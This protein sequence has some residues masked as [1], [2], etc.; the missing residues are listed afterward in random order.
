MNRSNKCAATLAAGSIA[1]LAGA[2]SAQCDAAN[3]FVTPPTVLNNG[4]GHGTSTGA[5]FLDVTGNGHLDLL[6]GQG[7]LIFDVAPD[8]AGI[9]VYPGDG[10][11]G[12]GTPFLVGVEGSANPS[13]TRGGPRSIAGGDLTGNG[14]K[15][16]VAGTQGVEFIRNNGDGTFADPVVF[17]DT[18]PGEGINDLDIADVNG[19]GHLDIIATDTGGATV[20]IAYN[21]GMGNFNLGNAEFLFSLRPTAARAGD[22]NNNGRID[23]AIANSQTSP[24]SVTVWFQQ[25][26]GTFVSGGDMPL[27]HGPEDLGVGDF[28]ND[29]NLDV[30]VTGGGG[31]G[32][33]IFY[34][35]GAGG[36]TPAQNVAITGTNFALEL[37]VGDIDGDGVDDIA[38]GTLTTAG[39][40]ALGVLL[41]NGDRTFREGLAISTGLPRKVDLGDLNG[42]GRLEATHAIS[43]FSADNTPVFENGCA[44]ICV[45]D[46]NG[47]GVV[48]A[49]DFF[50]FLTLFAA[51]DPIADINGDGVIDADDFFAYLSLFA[52]GC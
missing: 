1:A 4:S 20:L 16:I 35:D 48:D 25:P 18:G 19:N 33:A 2:A 9:A 34:G 51:A 32:V 21:D 26:N 39:S 15:D 17:Y 7:K 29:G 42:N 11:G 13:F 40:G 43:S 30:V 27:L 23:I 5:R 8:R 22:F 50:L 3:A 37:A 44:D 45:A 12:F 52:A 46:L 31:G 49:D 38:V 10:N 36:F 47:D 41:S 28:D 6:V 14:F 24:P